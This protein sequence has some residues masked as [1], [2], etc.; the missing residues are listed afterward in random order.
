MKL[1]ACDETTASTKVKQH[2]V[3]AKGSETKL[4]SDGSNFIV[5][6]EE[7]TNHFQTTCLDSILQ[8]A[9]GH[10]A[11]VSAAATLFASHR[12]V[13]LEEIAQISN[14]T[15][16]GT[17]A[18][19]IIMIAKDKW[20]CTR[21]F[22]SSESDLQTHLSVQTDLHHHRG[23]VAFKFLVDKVTDADSEA[24]RATELKLSNLSL[25]EHNYDVSKLCT[26]LGSIVNT[27]K[28]NGACK[29]KHDNK[30]ISALIDLTCCEEHRMHSL[31][32]QC[33]VDNKVTVNSI[34]MTANID[35]E[36]KNLKK[37]KKWFSPVESKIDS[38]HMS[39]TVQ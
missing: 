4:K 36:H 22:N 25:Q 21:L 33:N 16:V 11:N 32:F 31:F 13:T 15:C 38:K 28:A 10:C 7:Q 20:L 24:I 9:A 3:V 29:N 34:V 2:K 39:M 19:E 8:L 37:S 18:A 17:S 35:N 30:I 23:L 26:K 1:I 6:F 14:T 5:Q 12:L 27:L